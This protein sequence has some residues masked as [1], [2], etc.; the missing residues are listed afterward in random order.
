[1]VDFEND[2]KACMQALQNDGVILYPTDTVW[3]LGCD[4][5]NEAA[6][7]KVFAVKQRPKEKSMII[8]LADARD[9]LHYVAAPPPDIIAMVEA[10][11][12]PT[13]VIYKNALGFPANV[14]NKDGSIAIRVTTD[15]FC[16]A[17]I[18]RLRRPIVST[19]ANISGEPTPAI[20]SMINP[21]IVA[22]VDYTVTHRQTDSSITPPSRLISM[23]DDGNITVLRD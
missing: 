20:F 14:V 22:G 8:L 16:K 11:E 1:M 6:V 3:G 12:R 15:P 23:D 2:I 10:F 7:D 18:K 5:L 17:L 13:T 4:A 21:S 9:I 19:S